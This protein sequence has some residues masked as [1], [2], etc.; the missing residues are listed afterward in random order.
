MQ[1]TLWAAKEVYIE[2]SNEVSP[3]LPSDW[4][5]MYWGD[6]AQG[7]ASDGTEDG[8]TWPHE[9]TDSFYAEEFSARHVAI[10]IMNSYYGTGNIYAFLSEVQF[11]IAGASVGFCR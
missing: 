7:P 4:T 8:N 9:M 10:S 6:L 2:A 3:S 1:R 5:E 11:E